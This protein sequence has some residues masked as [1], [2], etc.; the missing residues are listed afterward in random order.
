MNQTDQII[1]DYPNTY[2]FTKNLCERILNKRRGDLTLTIF[3]PA[4]IINSYQE[5]YEGWVDSVAAAVAL[6]FFCGLGVIKEI[7]G[8]PRIIGDVITVDT[9]SNYIIVSTAYN[10]NTNKLAV[11]HSSSSQRNPVSWGQCEE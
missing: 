8:N 7:Y 6:F 10:A 2:T 3:R 4:V 1:G 11:F 5:P 9:V